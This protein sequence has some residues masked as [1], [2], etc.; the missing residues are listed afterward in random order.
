[1]LPDRVCVYST[2]SVTLCGRSLVA[3][4]AGAHAPDLAAWASSIAW[5][6][7]AMTPDLVVS[8]VVLR[9]AAGRILTVRK[10]GTKRF[11]LPGGKH[12][13]GESA[14]D[15]AVRECA[16]ELGLALDPAGLTEVGVFVADAANEPGLT[17]RGHV[18]AHPMDAEPRRAAEI[19]QLRWLDPTAPLPGDLAPLLQ[20]HILPALGWGA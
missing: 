1:M 14:A 17:V 18:F 4:P 3:A 9:D 5:H 10:A 19:A 16:E 15:A 11:M 7:G 6:D 20:R 13:P 2:P 8:A 12:E